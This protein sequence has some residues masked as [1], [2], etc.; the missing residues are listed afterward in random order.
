VRGGRGGRLLEDDLGAFLEA[1][2]EFGFTTAVADAQLHRHF[3]AAF[4]GGQSGLDRSLR[5]LS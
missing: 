3:P 1:G 4:F 5:S 2:H